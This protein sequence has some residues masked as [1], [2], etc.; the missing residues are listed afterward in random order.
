LF[1]DSGEYDLSLRTIDVSKPRVKGLLLFVKAFVDTVMA[2]DI[3]DPSAVI[4]RLPSLLPPS[5]KMLA[6]TT[7]AIAALVHT[8]MSTV[9]FR[10]IAV[11][12]A[13]PAQ[14][15]HKNVLFDEWN[16][17][18]PGSYTFRYRHD[19]SSLEFVL[20]LTK[21]GGRTLINAIA[22]EAGL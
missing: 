16:A 12:D 19:Q 7:D 1:E 9:D 2:G 14:S 5:S 4:D 17:H 20:K 13:S 6:T 18:G 21:L 15:T 11:D 3:L 10:L 8:A 22:V